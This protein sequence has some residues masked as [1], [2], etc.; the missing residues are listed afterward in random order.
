MRVSNSE[1]GYIRIEPMRLQVEEGGIIL[2]FEA[3]GMH[4]ATVA[5]VKSGQ[6][7]GK[8]IL[9]L[10]NRDIKADIADKKWVFIEEEAI[11]CLVEPEKGD[12]FVDLIGVSHEYGKEG[13]IG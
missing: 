2:P 13:W 1:F 12:T 8:Y 11:L 4:S 6:Y 7:E 10:A 5:L 9:F 3:K